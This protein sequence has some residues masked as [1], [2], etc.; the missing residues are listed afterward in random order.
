MRLM[1]VGQ[2]RAAGRIVR[3][4]AVLIVPYTLAVVALTMVVGYRPPTWPDEVAARSG[5]VTA[6][7]DHTEESVHDV[8]HGTAGG[9]DDEVGGTGSDDGDAGSTA[10]MSVAT[11]DART[12][13]AP[14]RA[15]GDDTA[16]PGGGATGG[17]GSVPATYAPTSTTA[18][19]PGSSLDEGD[20]REVLGLVFDLGRPWA[21]KA[22]FIES[23]DS[24][25]LP[26][27]QLV[28][29]TTAFGTVELRVSDVKVEGDQAPFTVDAYL[30][31]ALV[32]P[33]IAGTAQRV[34]PAWRLTRASLCDAIA[35]AAVTCPA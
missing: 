33:G 23:A 9:S 27:Q 29:A 30:N 19:A 3:G 6:G 25:A 24:L 1:K 12:P 26:Y 11:E 4:R 10:P 13:T 16:G 28:A 20:V 35:V 22:P 32:R 15:A 34:G 8:G 18:P 14:A 17:G 2:S 5:T 31:G 21:Q 7:S